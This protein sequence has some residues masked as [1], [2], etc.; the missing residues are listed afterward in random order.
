MAAP[1]D[2]VDSRFL[3]AEQLV[4]AFTALGRADHQAETVLMAA[5]RLYVQGMA[6]T[7]QERG[8]LREFRIELSSYAA[9]LAELADELDAA[10]DELPFVW[11][12][13]TTASEQ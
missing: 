4:G 5:R 11:P 9:H 13:E 8:A 10:I 6:A 12:E 3:T 7:L 1:P 2:I